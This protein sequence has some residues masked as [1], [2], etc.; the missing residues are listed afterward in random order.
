MRLDNK[1]YQEQVNSKGTDKNKLKLLDRVGYILGFLILAFLFCITIFYSGWGSEGSVGIFKPLSLYKLSL[2]TAFIFS[3]VLWLY[4][5]IKSKRRNESF[6]ERVFFRWVMI[7]FFVMYC[8]PIAVLSVP[9]EIKMKITFPDR[10]GES[11][12][13]SENWYDEWRCFKKKSESTCVDSQGGALQSDECLMYSAIRSGSINRCSE[14]NPAKNDFSTGYP[15]QHSCVGLV[16]GM[17]NVWPDKAFMSYFNDGYKNVCD[18]H[19]SDERR[20]YCLFHYSLLKDDSE[21]CQSITED[22]YRLACLNQK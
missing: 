18:T 11:C 8:M 12:L 22:W 7:V 9:G 21:S 5:W 17:P 13:D 16:L 14:I 2:Q 4:L 6:S 1:K 19:F 15:L 20:D 10:Y 3:I